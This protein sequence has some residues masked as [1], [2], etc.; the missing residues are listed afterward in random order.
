MLLLE[1]THREMGVTR[2][3]LRGYTNDLLDVLTGCSA[4]LAGAI[5]VAY[6]LNR[7]D[8]I[9]FVFTAVPAITGLMSYVRLAWRSTEVETP[10]RLLLHS[11]GLVISVAGWLILVGLFTAL[12]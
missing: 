11:P 3:A 4:F 2:K 9:P 10:E 12:G 5:Y 8:R 7:P 1:K 6:C